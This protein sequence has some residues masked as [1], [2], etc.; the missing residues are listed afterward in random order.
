MDSL[1]HTI[2]KM[3]GTQEDMHESLLKTIN[4]FTGVSR[5]V[6]QLLATLTPEKKLDEAIPDEKV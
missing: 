4:V 3:I 1:C 6:Q 2:A 5:D